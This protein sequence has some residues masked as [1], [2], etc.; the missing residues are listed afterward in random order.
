MSA[1]Y[2]GY[3]KS[4]NAVDAERSGKF[5]ST[6]AARRTGLPAKFIQEIANWSSH[7]EWH[8]SSKYF[9]QVPYYDTNELIAWKEGDADLVSEHGPFEQAFTAWKNAANIAKEKPAVIYFPARVKWIEWAGT[10]N[11]PRPVEHDEEGAT[12]VDAGGKFV[13]VKLAAGSQF[14]KGKETNGFEVFEA[15][16]KRVWFK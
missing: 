11:Y 14:K 5:P 1:G 15:N 8:H 10:R 12:V 16:G 6:E 2:S 4:N 7:G 9:N 3:S 13:T